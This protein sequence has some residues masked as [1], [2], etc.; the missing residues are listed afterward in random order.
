MFTKKNKN[1]KLMQ[2]VCGQCFVEL[3]GMSGHLLSI[4]L[5]LIQKK[6]KKNLLLKAESKNIC[7][8]VMCKLLRYSSSARSLSVTGTYLHRVD[9]GR[10]ILSLQECQCIRISELWPTVSCAQLWE[11]LYP[12]S[13]WLSHRIQGVTAHQ[14]P[15]AFW[16][17]NRLS[18]TFIKHRVDTLS[19]L[20]WTPDSCDRERDSIRLVAQYLR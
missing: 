4:S 14:P 19:A 13:T 2:L 3:N 1:K 18:R 9:R 7:I 15:S 8:Y 11:L 20:K 16:S 6:K 17:I 10:L 12:G 5:Q